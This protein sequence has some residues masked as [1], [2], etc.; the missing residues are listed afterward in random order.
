MDLHF[1]PRNA[2]RHSTQSFMA[3]HIDEA[4]GTALPQEIEQ[5]N[6]EYKVTSLAEGHGEAIYEIGVS[7]HGELVGLSRRDMAESIKTLKQMGEMLNADVSIIRERVIQLSHAEYLKKERMLASFNS[8]QS[9]VGGDEEASEDD[10]GFAFSLDLDDVNRQKSEIDELMEERVVAEVLVRKGLEDDRHFLEIRV[11]IVGGA[12]AGKS[13]LLGV[14]ADSELDNGRGKSR[15]NLLRHRH[16]IESGRTSSISHQIIGFN[17]QGGIVNYGSTNISTLEQICEASAK[18]VS[19]LDTAGH[20][21]YQKTT[22]SGLTGHSPDYAC[23]ILGANAGG[24]SEVPREHL[25]IAVALMVPV[26]IVITK[27]DVA[28]TEQLTKTVNSLLRL[29]KSPGICRVPM[30]IQNEDD[31][32]V[33]VSSLVNSRVIPIFLTSSVTGEN[34][35]L[36][37][38]FLNLLP[39]PSNST[40]I[41]PLDNETLEFSVEET[42][43]IPGLGYVVG[44]LLT[45]GHMSLRSQRNEVFYLGPD[46]G[47]F[48]PIQITSIHRQRIPIAHLTMGQA[49]T[50]AISFVHKSYAEGGVQDTLSPEGISIRK[51][52]LRNSQNGLISQNPPPGFKVRKG[53]VILATKPTIK[54]ESSS[55]PS[56]PLL[57]AQPLTPTINSD[58]MT[59]PKGN[60]VTVASVFK[61]ALPITACAWEF[62]AEIHVIHGVGSK[63]NVT[64]VAVGTSGVAYLGSVRQ[65]ARIV[66]LQDSTGK[67]AGLVNEDVSINELG[68]GVVDLGEDGASGDYFIVPAKSRRRSSSVSTS[69]PSSSSRSGFRNEDIL[70]VTVGA[71]VDANLMESPSLSLPATKRTAD[72]LD[73][74]NALNGTPN[75]KGLVSFDLGQSALS[76]LQTNTPEGHGTALSNPTKRSATPTPS[77]PRRNAQKLIISSGA[78]N[79]AQTGNTL[80][81]LA[82]EST[83]LDYLIAPVLKTGSNGRIRLRFSHEP[84]W[85]KIGSTVLFRGEERLKCVGKVVGV[86]LSTS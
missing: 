6:V 35:N 3:T 25:G 16:E 54:E 24:V 30:V 85:V 69:R 15:L 49:A 45:A 56:S 67:W 4:G 27:V 17:A 51:K 61:P 21:K 34:M 38:K 42:Y 31:L 32:V 37:E 36:L 44:G 26:F 59:S 23:L 33:A 46:R 86:V 84:E 79:S 74:P 18:I 22:L 39:K 14:L 77:S 81:Q 80:S 1:S 11:A 43:N 47:Q 55:I 13:T 57:S 72:V 7:D 66:K 48:V 12:A 65:G 53:Q 50:C 5:G 29:L 73:S 2:N 9:L 28:S 70:G 10:D 40:E 62:E 60:T 75:R 68:V 82:S 19:F 83:A 78:S 20:P 76:T 58:S 63:N 52:S 8:S 71:T 64:E 41:E